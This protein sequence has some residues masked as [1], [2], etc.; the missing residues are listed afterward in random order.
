MDT[1]QGG[2]WK[3]CAAQLMSGHAGQVITTRNSTAVARPS[4][5]TAVRAEKSLAAREKRALTHSSL[6]TV[7][8]LR[9]MCEC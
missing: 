8:Q 5:G 4:N 7:C 6:K 9:S 1:W 2:P 3:R